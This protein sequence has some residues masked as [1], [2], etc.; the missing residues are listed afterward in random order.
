M[1]LPRFFVGYWPAKLTCLLNNIMQTGWGIIACIA[2]GQLISAVNGHGLSIAV[3]CA[4]A[5]L[6]NGALCTFGIATLHIYKRYVS[7]ILAR[8]S[9]KYTDR[10]SYA[11]YPQARAFLV[12]IGSSGSKWDTSLVSTGD[13]ATVTA[14]RCSF[15]ALI[16]AIVVGF[17]AISSDFYVYYPVPRRK[18]LTFV[19]TW[20]GIWIAAV[21]SEL[22]GVGIATGVAPNPG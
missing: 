11:W 3:G 21:I 12:L 13:S 10:P 14:N 4:I 22:V 7:V 8:S 1:V 20:A 2:A 19:I 6:C 15:F 16:F 17:S 9:R 5:A 18:S